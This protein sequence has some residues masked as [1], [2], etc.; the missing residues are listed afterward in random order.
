MRCQSSCVLALLLLLPVLSACDPCGTTIGCE[1]AL[2]V[3]V[4]GRIVDESTGAAIAGAQLT[5]QRDGGGV[6]LEPLVSSTRSDGAGAFELTARAVSAGEAMV[7]VSVQAPGLAAYV[8]PGMR[9]QTKTRDGEGTVLWPW[10]AQRPH[11][12]FVLIVRRD[13][14]TEIGVDSAHVEFRR[15]AGPQLVFRDAPIDTLRG[16]TD[17]MGWLYLFR[18]IRA[19]RAG[20]VTG[21]LLIWTS[22]TGDTLVLPQVTWEAVPR[23]KQP[24]LP[25]VVGIGAI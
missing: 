23:F 11:F 17:S 3:T 4:T 25:V 12:P 7:R 6:G 19:D 9:V 10:T 18:D 20:T 2:H 24:T 22:A 13:P 5:M 15:T 16:Y 21:D 8:V 14:F 1:S